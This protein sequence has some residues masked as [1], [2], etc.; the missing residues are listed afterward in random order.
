MLAAKDSKGW[1][2]L[3]LGVEPMTDF[4]IA[5]D[6]DTAAVLPGGASSLAGDSAR[7]RGYLSDHGGPLFRI[8]HPA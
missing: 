5:M 2:E 6:S 3:N 1:T 8:E 7:V 4:T